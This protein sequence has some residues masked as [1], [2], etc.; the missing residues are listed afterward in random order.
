MINLL[1]LYV[2]FLLFF[3]SGQCLLY[4]FIIFVHIYFVGYEQSKNRLTR[5]LIYP[6]VDKIKRCLKTK[7]QLLR[8]LRVTP[9]QWGNGA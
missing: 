2:L 4:L 7:C 5:I 9:A 3:I 8:H 6:V 1:F